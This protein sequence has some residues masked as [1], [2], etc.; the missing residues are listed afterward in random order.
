MY[1]Y[2]LYNIIMISFK[3]TYLSAGLCRYFMSPQK[4]VLI[5]INNT[6]MNYFLYLFKHF[7][8]FQVTSLTYSH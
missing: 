3:L 5:T 7:W 1:A 8:V 4:K 6:Y 2:C